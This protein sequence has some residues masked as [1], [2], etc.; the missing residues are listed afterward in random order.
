[1]LSTESIG[2]EKVHDYVNRN[3]LFE[4][5]VNRD[6]LCSNDKKIP[7]STFQMHFSTPANFE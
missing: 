4:K 6:L 1:M 2:S 7:P 5:D 3:L